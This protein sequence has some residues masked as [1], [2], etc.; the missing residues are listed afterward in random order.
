MDTQIK[1]TK[2]FRGI[3]AVLMMTGWAS[4]GFAQAGAGSDTS[5]G[6]AVQSTSK[7]NQEAQNSGKGR[8]VKQNLAAQVAQLRQQVSQLRD[9]MQ[10]QGISTPDMMR[11][12]MAMR[13]AQGMG[14]QKMGPGNSM[15]G[16]GGMMGMMDDNMMKM[17]QGMM[18]GGMGAMATMGGQG[19][20]GQMRRSA[21]ISM[22]PGFPGASHLYHIGATNFF[23][24]H[25]QHIVLSPNQ[26]EKLSKLREETMMSQGESQRKIQEAEQE[27]WQLTSADQP[28]LSKIES[29]IREIEQMKGDERIEYIKSV[30]EAAKILADEQRKALLGQSPPMGMPQNSP[31]IAMGS[32][33]MQQ[34]AQGGGMMMDDNMEMPPMGGNQASGSMPSGGGMGDM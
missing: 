24:D 32:G 26:Q 23:L 1:W 10:Q 33:T 4:L 2:M 7:H 18:G 28:N 8:A 3:V 5:G 6:S 22:L 27:L 15:G 31:A 14:M 16:A 30:G 9:A 11:R 12:G 29:K 20:P 34:G 19:M 21:T 13:S 25:P 17:M